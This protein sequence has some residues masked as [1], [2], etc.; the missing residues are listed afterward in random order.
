MDEEWMSL[1][2]APA[3]VGGGVGVGGVGGGGG[4][5]AGAVAGARRGA[6]VSSVSSG[7]LAEV[8]GALR[9]P[10]TLTAHALP[11]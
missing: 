7:G 9:A 2:P 8:S 6:L 11:V 10:P 1:S 5:E 4:T 3:G